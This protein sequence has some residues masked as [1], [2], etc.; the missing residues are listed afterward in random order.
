MAIFLPGEAAREAL[1]QPHQV[2]ERLG[3]V[4]DVALQVHDRH[5]RGSRGRREVVVDALLHRRA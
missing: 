5:R 4:V 3:R 2:G 1:A